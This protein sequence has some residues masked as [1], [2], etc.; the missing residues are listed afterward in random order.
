[1]TFFKSSISYFF[2]FQRPR[3]RSSITIFLKSNH[4]ISSVFEDRED[5]E[6]SRFDSRWARFSSPVLTLLYKTLIFG[7][8]LLEPIDQLSMPYTLKEMKK[9]SFT[10]NDGGANIEYSRQVFDMCYKNIFGIVGGI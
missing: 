9:I 5:E 2:R 6:R 7:H 4:R 1:M 3:S 8:L 10:N